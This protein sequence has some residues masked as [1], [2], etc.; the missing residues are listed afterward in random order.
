MK[1]VLL[2]TAVA[3]MAFTSCS[4]N[5]E[6]EAQGTNNEIKI[7]TMVKK[8]PRAV[9]TDDETFK[10]FTLSSFIVDKDQIYSEK[11][12]GD[13]YMDGV[14]YTGIKGNWTNTGVNYYWPIGKNVQFFGY[15]GGTNFMVNDTGYPTL[16]FSIKGT[17]S[18]QEDL[19]V[20]A[21]N[22]EKPADD[23]AKVLLEFK[24]ILTKINFSYKPEA[25]YTYEITKLKING[26]KGGNATYTFNAD[27]LQGTWTNGSSDE[28]YEYP[29][30]TEGANV[31]EGYYPLDSKDGSLMLLP[32]SF[33]AETVSI[34]ITYTAKR[35]AYS[36][37]ATDKIIKIPATTWKIGQSVRYKLA[38]P[39][40]EGVI[41]VE[42][43]VLKNWETET[44][45]TL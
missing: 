29:I 32:Q 28:A 4:Q 11:G 14:S 2:A 20:A 6:F 40:G 8:S 45:S 22:T 37:T 1:K 39:A 12:L 24:H 13:A 26:V 3:A 41:S 21:M 23:N 38:L 27:P 34:Q 16:S 33:A 35:G 10:S 9:V 30:T 44:S 19:V 42:T 5:E 17:S 25:D 18:E 15:S 43:E 31:S 7:G 36:Y